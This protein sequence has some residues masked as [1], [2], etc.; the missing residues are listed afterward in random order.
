MVQLAKNVVQSAPFPPFTIQIYK[1]LISEKI[2]VISSHGPIKSYYIQARI[3][4]LLT[5]N[6]S[7][8]ALGSV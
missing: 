5:I 4:K 6:Q 7:R 2:Q 3:K 1:Y 8:K